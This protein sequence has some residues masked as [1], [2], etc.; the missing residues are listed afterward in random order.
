MGPPL[1]HALADLFLGHQENFWL[2]T[3]KVSKILFYWR[4]VDDNFC[5]FET[6]R[7]APLFFDLFNTRHPNIRFTMD[8]KVDHKIPFLDVFI[9]NHSQGPT[10]T[11][12]GKRGLSGLLIYYFSFTASS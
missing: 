2:E 11:V 5:V 9:H 4:Y 7:D 3:Y 8:N 10:T 6:E 12:F 1:A